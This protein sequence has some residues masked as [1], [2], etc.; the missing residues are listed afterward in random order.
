MNKVNK[1]LILTQKVDKEDDLLGF[2][3]GWL[4][5]LASH[6]EK[7]I[8]ICLQRGLHTLPRNVKVMSLGKE[9]F[10]RYPKFSRFIYRLVAVLR[11]YEY[12]IRERKSYDRVFVHMNK[13]YVV[14]GGWLWKLFNKKVALWYNHGKGSFW[15]RLAGRWSNIIFY[16]SPFSF[17]A[18]WS[19]AKIMPVGIDTDVFKRLEDIKKIKNSVL[20]LGRISPVKNVMMLIKAAKIMSKNGAGFTLNIVGDP[21][22]KDKS[23]FHNIKK[24]A[25][26]LE[27]ENKVI[28]SKKIPNHKTPE[29]Y[30]QNEIFVNLTN[31]GSMDKTT[32]E[33]MA[34]ENLVLVSNRSFKKIFPPAWHDLL[35]FKESDTED[36]ANKLVGLLSLD[37]DKKSE[38]GKKCRE[39]VKTNHSLD[40][41]VNKLTI[42]LDAE[43]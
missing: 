40:V 16:T 18:G 11:F 7:I 39:I 10:V 1:I 19:K 32:L 35:I 5:K 14:L 28:F 34:C 22:E 30:N 31:S 41:L 15:S 13:E 38:M 6:Y 26:K 25:Q 4:E 33:A 24:E 9:E 21:G 23:Y 43:K 17:F 37:N 29:I 3:H 36:L 8:V 20:Y 42:E 12:I 2:F 27:N